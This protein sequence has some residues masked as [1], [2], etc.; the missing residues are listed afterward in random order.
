MRLLLVC[1]GLVLLVTTC[2]DDDDST[3][4]PHATPTP[5]VSSNPDAADALC[6]V[7]SNEKVHEAT[8]YAVIEKVPFSAVNTTLCTITL[9]VLGCG[10]EC[11]ISVNDLGVP[12]DE[13]ETTSAE[14]RRTW[15]DVHSQ[16]S[17]TFE[18][19]P[20]G[21]ESWLGVTQTMYPGYEMLY[22]LAGDHAYAV[23]GPLREDDVVPEAAI[24]D[25]AT[26]IAANVGAGS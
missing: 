23:S 20:V 7:I 3:P 12:S 11:S 26:E 15:L 6:D 22:F 17:P 24:V 2:G 9:N 5:F 21:S 8:G 18:E 13:L 1:A 4:T 16:A 14:F 10:E 25:I 19:G